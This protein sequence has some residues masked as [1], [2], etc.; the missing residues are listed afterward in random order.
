MLF[1]RCLLGQR[2]WLQECQ[3]HMVGSTVLQ[4]LQTIFRKSQL[5][6]FVHECASL[7]FP[8][9]G[10]VAYYMT[11]H[12]RTP[13]RSPSGVMLVYCR[14]SGFG[15]NVQTKGSGAAGWDA[16]RLSECPCYSTS[17]SLT[18]RIS[19]AELGTWLTPPTTRRR[20]LITMEEAEHRG[21]VIG[22]SLSHFFLSG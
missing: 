7:S 12:W 3:H 17:S 14:R 21:K 5:L 22:A 11:L 6:L 15:R 8:A 20:S 10:T 16:F 13:P 1:S 4:H 9:G 19:W 18:N 2:N